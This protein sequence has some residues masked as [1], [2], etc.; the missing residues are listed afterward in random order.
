MKIFFF[1]LVLVLLT[2]SCSSRT[3]QALYDTI[4]AKNRQ[5]CLNQGRSDCPRADEYNEY[6]KQRKE[7]MQGDNLNQ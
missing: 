6:E 1:S 4:N 7:V 2:T 5:D 3:K